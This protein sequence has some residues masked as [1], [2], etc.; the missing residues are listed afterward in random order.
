MLQLLGKSSSINVR[1]VLWTLH[2]LELPFQQQPWGDAEFPVS[3]AE[4]LAINP[5]GLVPVL[6]DGEL[7]LS[8]SNSICRY[9]AAKTA[10]VDLLP[11]A[12]QAR[13]VIEQWMDWQATDL[14]NAWR[15][16]FMGL[17]RQHPHFQ[18]RAAIEQSIRQWNQAITVMATQLARTGAYICGSQLTLADIVLGVSLNRWRCTP[19]PHQD[20]PEI[21]AYER[22]LAQHSGYLLYAANGVP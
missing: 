12:P 3:S 11:Q 22:L 19:M 14:N 15:Y 5:A 10:R 2:E 6:R 13:A 17:V 7:V 9:L 21:Q 20:L 8:E 18:D 4:F 1:K 16:A